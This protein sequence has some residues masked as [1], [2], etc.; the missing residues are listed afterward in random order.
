MT[1][2]KTLRMTM[3]VDIG[4]WTKEQFQEMLDQGMIE[5]GEDETIEQYMQEDVNEQITA[6][7]VAEHLVL[8]PGDDEG[9]AGSG[10]FKTVLDARLVDAEWIET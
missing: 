3:D 7:E 4:S 6:S 1:Q 8:A 10:L 5:L 9:F 2:K